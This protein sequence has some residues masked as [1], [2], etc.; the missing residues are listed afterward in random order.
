MGE[1]MAGKVGLVTGAGSGIGRAIALAFANEGVRVIIADIDVNG[2]QETAAQVE[3]AGSEAAFVKCDVRKAGEVETM[4]AACI[5]KF[6]RL[7]YA[8]NN[9]G[10]HEESHETLAD[11]KETVWD[12]II[13]VNLK[14]V[15]L[16]MKYEIQHM[17][18]QGNGVIVNTA[19]IGGLCVPT[20][21]ASAYVASKHGIMGLTKSAA[22]EYA[23]TGIRINAVCPAVIDTPMFESAPEEDK[24]ML[25]SI[26]PVGRLGRPEE[27][28]GAVMWLC[29]DLA[30]FVTGTGVLVDGGVSIG[31]YICHL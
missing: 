15:F 31:A 14:G 27:V 4:I 8:C 16:C 26:H 29:S 18:K 7:D 17:L 12:S 24:Q 21:G 5:N 3:T 2:G 11:V 19:S 25:S 9:A 1:S 23:K 30:G 13:E 28:A 20:P 6:G 10:I 22:L